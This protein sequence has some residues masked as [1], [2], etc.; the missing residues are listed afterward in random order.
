MLTQ[1]QVIEIF[2]NNKREN[3]SPF[4]ETALFNELKLDS[5]KEMW[6]IIAEHLVSCE[7]LIVADFDQ[8]DDNDNYIYPVQTDITVEALVD[9]DE[10]KIIDFIRSGA[11]LE[12]GKIVIYK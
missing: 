6:Y 3:I 7:Y 8:I 2:N 10:E 9:N 4:Y 11:K 5:N 12:N 1:Q